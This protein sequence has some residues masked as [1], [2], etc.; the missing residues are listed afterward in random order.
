M[1]A[2]DL[3]PNRL[4]R[5]LLDAWP[6]CPLGLCILAAPSRSP[7]SSVTRV[8]DRCGSRRRHDGSV[9]I[10]RW[11]T[12]GGPGW[13]LSCRLLRCW[14][15]HAEPDWRTP[16][17]SSR[18][19]NA[20]HSRAGDRDRVGGGEPGVAFHQLRQR[21]QGRRLAVDPARDRGVDA[22]AA[23]GGGHR[24]RIAGRLPAAVAVVGDH[25]RADDPTI[26]AGKFYEALLSIPNWQ[27]DPLTIAAQVV[28]SSA[29]PD[30]Y[31]DDEPLARQLLGPVSPPTYCRSLR[32]AITATSCAEAGGRIRGMWCFHYRRVRRTGTATT[33][34]A[35]AVIGPA[36][37]PVM[38]CRLPAGPRCWPPPLA[39]WCSAPTNRGLGRSW[40]RSAPAPVGCTTWYAH[41]RAVTVAG[42]HTGAA[43][44][45]IGEVGDLGNATGCHL[46]F[47]VHP[48][49]GSIYQ[50]S[51]DPS[52]WLKAARRPP[53]GGDP[54]RA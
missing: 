54:A 10:P 18:R 28:Q 23:R 36:C 49:G 13:A 41:M 43:G 33:S 26:A 8:A 38:T 20:W 48:H 32:L 42:R 31:A 47:E 22:P 14:G 44:Q 34:V 11:Q 45:Q 24:S 9:R 46:H 37:T 16:G 50:D 40:S 3:S 1:R 35:E 21:R 27:S 25:A 5:C 12:A 52:A 51:V 39:R 30:A 15:A 29:Y 6:T 2:A 7:R 19:A 17:R 53:D 4:R